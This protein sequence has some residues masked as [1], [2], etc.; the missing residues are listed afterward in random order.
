MQIRK[1]IS[2]NSES[3]TSTEHKL[4]A[5]LLADYPFAGLNPIQD[6]SALTK[7]STA[8]ISR[9]VNKIGFKG[10]HEFQ[11][12]L[13]EELKAGQR[14]PIDLYETRRPV[15]HDNFADFVGRAN[16][17]M[18]MATETVTSAQFEV[19]CK[20]FADEQ[21]NIFVIGGRISDTIAQFF[22]RHLQQI[23]PRVYHLPSDP[24]TW[25]EYIL[26]MKSKDILVI[27]DFRRYQPNLASL[28]EHAVKEKGTQIVLFT[29][30]WLSP[31]AGSAKHILG[32]PIEIG[33]IWDSYVSAFALIEAMLARTSEINWDVVGQRIESWDALRISMEQKDDK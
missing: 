3:F 6:L 27:I 30:K 9:F 21:R 28:A 16:R 5:A 25:P 14:S 31:I 15:S 33:T 19:L 20:L 12:Q 7:V 1:L 29:D 13:I 22:S 23:R 32:L 17:L 18:D 26:R 8:S 11:R 24:E 2:Q 10:Y 4:S